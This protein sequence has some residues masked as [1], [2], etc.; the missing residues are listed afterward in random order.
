MDLSVELTDQLQ[1]SIATDTAKLP[2][3]AELVVGSGGHRHHRHC[4][5]DVPLSGEPA[6]L[7]HGRD[8]TA[9]LCEPLQPADG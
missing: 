9:Q 8:D 6:Q 4:A 7:R 1:V 5:S 3:S 2:G